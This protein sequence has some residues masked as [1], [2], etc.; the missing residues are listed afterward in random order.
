MGSVPAR[1]PPPQKQVPAGSWATAY[2]SR[3]IRSQIATIQ[4]KIDLMPSAR[5]NKI[6]PIANIIPTATA[7]TKNR[8]FKVGIVGAGSAGLFTAMLFDHLKKEFN[9][10]VDYEI[11][12]R[13][14][15]DRVGGRLY[16]YHFPGGQEHHYFDVGAMRFPKISIMN[17]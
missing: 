12:E 8:K 17:R 2:A 15:Q 5:L 16:T 4:N 7:P 10:D 1:S 9:L 3:A 13:N 14:G 6:A 11:L